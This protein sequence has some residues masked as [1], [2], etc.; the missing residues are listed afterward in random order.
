MLDPKI[1][2]ILRLVRDEAKKRGLDAALSFH[3]E[4]SHLMRIGNSSVSL[5]TSEDLTRLDARVVIG[6]REAT[7]TRMG[8]ITDVDVARQT[9][10][11]AEKKARVAIEKDYIPILD[12]VEESLD[13]QSQYD[14]RLANLDPAAKGDA[15]EKIFRT[16]GSNYNYSGAWSSGGTELYVLSTANENDAYHKVSDL[17]F[18]VVLKHPEKRWELRVDQTGWRQSDFSVDGAVEELRRLLPVYEDNKGVQ[19]TPDIYPVVLGPWALAELIE[20]AIWTGFIGRFYEEKRS[21]TAKSKRGDK[22]LGGNVTIVDD[23]EDENT[24]KHGFDLTGKRRKLFPLVE[25]GKLSNLLYDLSAAGKYGKEPTGHTLESMSIVLRPGKGP[26]DVLAAVSGYEKVFY[27][28][29][30]HYLNIPNVSEGIFTGSSRFSAFVIEHGRIVA[31]LLSSR[32]TDTFENI[33]SN[34]SIL[35]PTNVSVNVS[36]TYE[37]RAAVSMSVPTYA[38]I[39]NAKITD[40]ADSF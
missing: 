3:H 38:V 36:N 31:P 23:P 13:E 22:I 32:I 10:E 29:A 34:V 16:V 20:M 24:F 33:F 30:L 25:E 39:G 9:L 7:H 14:G 37:R 28:P 11:I 35:G 6:R 4:Q 40:S 17:Q 15:Y 21:W 27:I 26:E 12:K 18:S 8:E 19:L 2:D 1:R 5:N